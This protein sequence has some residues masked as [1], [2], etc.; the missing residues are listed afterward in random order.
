MSFAVLFSPLLLLSKG[1]ERAAK[2]AFDGQPRS[3][4]PQYHLGSDWVSLHI[5]N[6]LTFLV[7][8]AFSVL[9]SFYPRIISS[10]TITL[11]TQ[12]KC[13]LK[14]YHPKKCF[15]ECS[16]PPCMRSLFLIS[17]LLLKCSSRITSSLQHK[18][19]C[20]VNKCCHQCYFPLSTCVLPVDLFQ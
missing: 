8:F 10:F 17:G 7:L 13:P 3:N 14:T 4:A 11:R 20:P 15:P 18:P 6:N 19:H 16:L 1:S 2:W 5:Q 12:G 9:L